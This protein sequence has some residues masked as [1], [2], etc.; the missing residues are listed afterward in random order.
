[1]PACS[2]RYVSGL[3]AIKIGNFSEN[4]QIF[5]SERHEHLQFLNTIW[6]GSCT[7]CQQGLLAAFQFHSCSFV[8]LLCPPPLFSAWTCVCFAN[9]KTLR[10]FSRFAFL[11]LDK[12]E[13]NFWIV[14]KA[15][16]APETS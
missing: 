5:K 7:D 1:M 4:K 2:P 15:A 12:F 11:R 8:S 16:S 3:Y 13:N 10:K 9:Y 6:H 14:L